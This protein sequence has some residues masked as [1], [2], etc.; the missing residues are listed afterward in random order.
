[1]TSPRVVEL[2]KNVM[3][4][5]DRKAALLR[6]HFESTQTCVVNL[7]S[8]PGTG[9]TELLT[10]ILSALISSGASAAALVGDCA[11]DNDAKRL[12]ASGAPVRQIVTEGLCHL[13]VTMIDQHVQ[14]WDLNG[15]D[16]LYI[17]NVGN[18]VCPSAFDLGESIRVVLLSVT[19]GEDK[20]LKYPQMFNS[21]DLALITKMDLAGPCEFDLAVTRTNIETVSPGIPILETSARNPESVQA[22][23]D[24]LVQLRQRTLTTES[25]PTDSLSIT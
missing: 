13:E 5:H 24:H 10:E 16:F 12:E 6:R 2:R 1:M 4:R 8:S 3:N 9:K 18:L 23:V 20:P 15:I 17:E 25:V 11:T 7:V 14:G 19:E 21:A 22:V